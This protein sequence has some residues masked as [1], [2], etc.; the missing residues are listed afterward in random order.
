MINVAVIYYS[1]NGSVHRLAQAAVTAAE[2]AGARVRLRRVAE[3][4][5]PGLVAADPAW[6][7]HAE[8]TADIPTA[9]LADL[10]WA[11]AALFGTP[12]GFGQPAAQLR[13]FLD[14]TGE[15]CCRGKVVSSFVCAAGPHAGYEAGLPALDNAFYHWGAVIVPTLRR[16]PAQTSTQT[17]EEE[18]GDACA[19]SIAAVDAQTRRVVGVATALGRRLLAT[20]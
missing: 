18:P 13:R 9:S 11:D 12:S 6:A 4:A 7:A 20:A 14:T 8:A 16:A 2:R 5:P 15:I 1:S 10:E 3:L 17:P 19:E